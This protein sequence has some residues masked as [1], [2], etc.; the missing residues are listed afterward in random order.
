MGKVVIKEAQNIDGKVADIEIEGPHNLVIDGKGLTCLPALIDSHVHFRQP[1]HEAKEDWGT[2]AQAA[3]AGGYTTVIDMPNNEPPCV[4]AEALTQKQ[5]LVTKKLR[6]VDIPL[7]HYFYFG[8]DRN[9]LNEIPKVKELVAGIKVFM[10]SSTGTLLLDQQ[11]D[12]E[13]VFAL[14]A[15]HDLMISVHAEDEEVIRNNREKLGNTTDPA[16]HS[17]IRTPEAAV[18]ATQRAIA[19]SEKYGTRLCILHMSTGEEVACV[20]D[21]KKK[22]LPVHA[23]VTPHHL[24][25]DD[26]YYAKLGTKAQMNPPLRSSEHVRALWEGIQDETIDFIGTDHAPHTLAEKEQE[27]GKAPSGVP[28]IEQCL[29]LLL[30][31]HA[32]GKL[33]LQQIVRLTRSNIEKIFRLPSH[34][35]VVLVDLNLEKTVDD[36]KL[37][38]KCQW[39]PY[40]GMKLKG[41]PVCTILKG[42]VY[43]IEAVTCQKP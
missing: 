10:G 43:E 42:L 25:L 29:P 19:L 8:A 11:S 23:E 31:A 39:S 14:A 9:Y 35:D 15:E 12:L 4:T 22:G 41:W 1:G 21:A 20:R 6:S 27:Y 38:T 13:R 34:R 36:G 26:S 28:S 32:E 30:N 33:T 5:E 7:R 40:H 24:F 2:A 18:L 3:V 37:K 17:K 16:S